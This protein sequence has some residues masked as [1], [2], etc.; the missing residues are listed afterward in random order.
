MNKHF[1][2]QKPRFLKLSKFRLI[3]GLIIAISYSV[4]FY[5]FLYI[6]REAFRILSV[7]ENYDM[8][9][10]TDNEVNFYNLFFAFI[11]VIFGQS[12]F[13]IF[14]FDRPKRL[15]EN[16]NYRKTTIIN[17]QR[18]LN[19][20]F[21]SWFSKL[22]VIFGL[23]FGFA[24]HGGYYTFS[25]YPKYNYIFILIIIVLFFQTWHTIGLTFKRKSFKWLLFSIT[26]VSLFSF[27]LSRINVIDY[28]AINQKFLQKSIYYKYTLELPE[29]ENYK[30]LWPSFVNDIY[31]VKSKK[32]DN[33]KPIII[34]ENKEI[35]LNQ[36]NRIITNWKSNRREYEIP[37]M[38]YQLHI[39]KSTKMKFVNQLKNVLSKSNIT[40]IA[41]AVI[42]KNHKY[43][44]KYYQNYAFL[45]RMPKYN[46]NSSKINNELDKFHNVIEIMQPKSKECY[47]NNKLIET[48]QIKN[49]LKKLI[50][51]T[52]DYIIKYY[53]SD[54]IDFKSYFKVLTISK[55]AVQELRNEYSENKYSKQ[56]DNLTYEKEKEV[57]KKYPFRIL[58]LKNEIKK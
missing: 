45:M 28:K 12:I 36:I 33:L 25:L 15:F 24:M 4:T 16:K 19:W 55:K 30:K 40:K 1:L 29:T 52:P 9:I 22:A 58:E 23:W 53:I 2:H 20:N 42:P 14:L 11:S 54:N 46:N 6:I 48:Y 44:E 38:I 41:Y 37:L 26:I 43:N 56:Y 51:Q 35:K 18:V 34:I 13:F 21:L 5:S 8:W 17:D 39:D 49:T 57:C 3:V 31:V 32:S 47:I 50:K 10:L 7:T 27:V